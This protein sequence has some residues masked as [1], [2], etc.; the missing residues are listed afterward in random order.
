MS[1][2]WYRDRVVWGF[3][4]EKTPEF[5][6]GKDGEHEICEPVSAKQVSLYVSRIEELESRLKKAIEIADELAYAHGKWIADIDYEEFD[7]W[8]EDLK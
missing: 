2:E 1:E 4:A 8:R 6:Q 3:Y 5:Y 7:S